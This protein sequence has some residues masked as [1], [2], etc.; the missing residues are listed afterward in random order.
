MRMIG[1]MAVLLVGLVS[2]VFAF[3]AFQDEAIWGVGRRLFRCSA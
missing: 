1:M 3:E 2:T